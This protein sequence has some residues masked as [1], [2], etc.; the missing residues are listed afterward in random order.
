MTGAFVPVGTLGSTQDDI[1]AQYRATYI[2]LINSHDSKVLPFVLG[3]RL[4]VLQL[5]ILYLLLPP[6]SSKFVFYLRYPLVILT[7]YLTIQTI[8][9]CKSSR[10]AYGYGIGITSSWTLIWG[11]TVLIFRDARSEFRRIERRHGNK[12]KRQWSD[13]STNGDLVSGTERYGKQELRERSERKDITDVF[14]S[15]QTTRELG[16]APTSPPIASSPDKSTYYVWQPLPPT[17]FHRLRWVLGL[18]INLRGIGWSYQIPNLPPPPLSV[19]ST[20]HPP[21]PLSPLPPSNQPTR[22]AML[23][24]SLISLCIHW[25]ALDTLKYLALQDPYFLSLN[26]PTSLSPFPFPAYTRVALS[27]ISTYTGLSLIFSMPALLNSI[28]G[29]RILGI[30]AEPWLYPPFFGPLSEISSKGLAGLWGNWWHQIFRF[31][32]ESAGDS[33]ADALGQGWGK[34]TARGG[35]L[36]L[37]TAFFLSGFIHACGSYTSLPHT[38]PLDAFL[39]FALQAVGI[40]VQRAASLYLRKQGWR[41]RIPA[42]TRGIGNVAFVVAWCCVTGPVIADDFARAGLW[43]MEPVPCSLWRGE[44]WLWNSWVEWYPGGEHWWEWGW[45]V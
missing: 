4:L 31:G 19:L 8:R 11:L 18:L 5:L 42:W 22:S 17:F 1:H 27:L 35:A 3:Y 16:L 40:L 2:S 36:R 29:P 33:L 41:N 32:F 15:P 44:W 25:I 43:L 45:T 24:R 9:V 26:S 14:I 13:S 30:H 20:L 7:T 21:F 10:V 23:R 12:E 38:R 34:R 37:F 6:T 28:L 39:F